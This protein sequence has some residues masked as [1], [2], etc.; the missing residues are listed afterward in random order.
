MKVLVTGASGFVG[1]ALVAELLLSG[2]Q[3]RACSRVGARAPGSDAENFTISSID[4]STDWYDALQSIDAVVHL[5]ARVHVMSDDSSDPLSEFR[6]VNTAG[7]LNLARQ[8]ALVGVKR[9]VFISSIKVNGDWTSTDR[10]FQ[11]SDPVHPNEPYGQSKHEAEKGL[12]LL[13]KETELEVV[14]VRPPL[15]Y[16]LGVKAN[17]S[18]LARLVRRGLPVPLGAVVTN[19]RSLVGIE[20]LID[21]L[22]VCL[23]HPEAANQTFM[24]SDGE[25]LSTAALILRMAKAMDRRARLFAV[26][27]SVLRVAANLLGKR[28]VADRLLGNLQV[29]IE[30]N[31]LLLGWAPKISVD[32]GLR[33]A[34]NAT[35]VD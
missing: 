19:R 15:V 25:D 22:R 28:Q 35:A 24:V 13:A 1:R 23:D 7:T 30:L 27:C 32:D 5:A 2:H 14:I 6:R 8:A 33:N 26:P 9:L 12:R 10:P 4:G 11:P 18:A 31:N 29:S 17:F 21:F 16:G 34:L 3:V 20:N